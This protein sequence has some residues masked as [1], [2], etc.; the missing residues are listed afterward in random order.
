MYLNVLLTSASII[1]IKFLWKL[2]DT[3]KQKHWRVIISVMLC[4]ISW[5]PFYNLRNKKNTHEVF[6]KS[7]TSHI[8]NWV[9]MV[10]NR[11]SESYNYP[12]ISVLLMV[13]LSKC[14]KSPLNTRATMMDVF[15]IILLLALSRCYIF[16]HLFKKHFIRIYNFF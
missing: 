16:E 12:S 2:P 5:C 3:Y 6:T 14:L 15:R 1:W 11:A 10:L 7:N 9:Q 13:T 8:I 4:A